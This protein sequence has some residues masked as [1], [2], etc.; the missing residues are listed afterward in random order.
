MGALPQI[1]DGNRE[2]ADNFIEAVKNHFRLNHAFPGYQSYR[3]RIA[4][5]LSLIQGPTVAPWAIEQG[6]WLDVVAGPDDIDL[7]NQFLGQFRAY[8]QD[9]QKQQRAAIEIERLQMKWPE[10]DEYTSKFV[11]LAAQ[12]GY[13]L[14]EPATLKHYLD[15][16]PNSVLTKVAESGAMARGFQA[17]REQAVQ[18]VNAQKIVQ[19]I[20]ASRKEKN[21]RPNPTINQAFKGNQHPQGNQQWN[22]P[23]NWNTSNATRSDNDT[24]GVPM[25]LGRSRAP[26]NQWR[27]NN[28]NYQGNQGRT[29]GN[30][31]QMDNQRQSRGPNGQCFNCGQEGHFARNCPKKR[32]QRSNANVAY[33][34][35]NDTT[36]EPQIEEPHSP[37]ENLVDIH[38]AIARLEPAE[39]EALSNMMGPSGGGSDFQTA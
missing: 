32:Q 11:T 30:V 1:F 10:I 20:M 8:F 34:N 39:R 37:Y 16:L 38:S 27:N 35:D 17:I 29:Q 14:M 21:P 24:R 12:A 22:R 25:D 23:R 7:W 28:N 19:A 15:G 36:E 13:D 3:T 18:T 33:V 4:F 31:A 5:V 9:T 2:Q 26:N 6:D